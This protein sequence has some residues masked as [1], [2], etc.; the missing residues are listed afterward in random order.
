MIYAVILCI[1]LQVFGISE[2]FIILRTLNRMLGSLARETEETEPEKE[3][4][5]LMLLKPKP[6]RKANRF[7]DK[8]RDWITAKE[9]ASRR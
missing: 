9:T 3:G 8:S 7:T 1:I 2:L 4:I 6:K 5:D